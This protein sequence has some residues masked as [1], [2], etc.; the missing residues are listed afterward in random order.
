METGVKSNWTIGK[1]VAHQGTELIRAR[2]API[3]KEI[4]KQG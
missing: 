4:L 2:A 1:N 3:R